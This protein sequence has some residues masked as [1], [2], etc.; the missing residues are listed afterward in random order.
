MSEYTSA[1]SEDYSAEA[2]EISLEEFANQ[3]AFLRKK[4]LLQVVYGFLWWAASAVAM[5]FAL[6]ATGSTLYYFGGA[7]GSLFHWYRATKIYMVT[8][9]VG[10]KK[11]LPIETLAILATAILV[12]GSSVLIVPEY[13]RISSPTVGTCWASLDD[14]FVPVATATNFPFPEAYAVEVHCL[15]VLGIVL[16]VVVNVPAVN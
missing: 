8:R 3:I 2:Q 7:L 5:F 11:I 14:A 1:E 16:L 6:E 4:A 12:V 10:V 9:S 15:A 13:F